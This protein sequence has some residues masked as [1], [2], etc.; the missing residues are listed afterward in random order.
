MSRKI[1]IVLIIAISAFLLSLFLD[2]LIIKEVPA[3]EFRSKDAWETTTIK[4][5]EK[6]IYII[7]ITGNKKPESVTFN[8]SPIEEFGFR[9]EY[10]RIELLFEIPPQLIKI[11][12]NYLKIKGSYP[13]GVEMVNISTLSNSKDFYLVDLKIKNVGEKAIFNL[14]QQ[15]SYLLK[16]WGIRRPEAVFLNGTALQSFQGRNRGGLE[17]QLFKVS[18]SL[19]K[20][21]MNELRIK[22]PCAYSVRIRNYFSSIASGILLFDDSLATRKD[23]QPFMQRIIKIFLLFL[24]LSA[25][26]ILVNFVNGKILR[27]PQHNI[28]NAYLISIGLCLLFGLIIY[29]SNQFT[30]YCFLF[31]FKNF[32][33]TI[34]TI[35]C[36]SFLMISLVMA[37][38]DIKII[39]VSYSNEI[40]S[41]KNGLIQ[42]KHMLQYFFAEASQ[43]K[44]NSDKLFSSINQ[45]PFYKFILVFI[46]WLRGASFSDK[47][48]IIFMIDILLSCLLLIFRLK[49]LADALAY[50]AY[51]LLVLALVGKLITSRKT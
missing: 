11:G 31:F 1:I 23:S 10:G 6:N 25:I 17:E 19:V 35:F 29:L 37:V 38:R 44:F 47:C 13:Y 3:F 45:L 30:H 48:L 33:V 5:Y 16:I 12:T 49:F 43:H 50:P 36:A 51:F 7:K 42:Q 39:M 34:L 32:V 46:I 18:A 9:E 28:D 8:Y 26:W 20:I 27:M 14:T 22:G 2:A 4:L 15:D 40:Q 21:G 41:F 24:F